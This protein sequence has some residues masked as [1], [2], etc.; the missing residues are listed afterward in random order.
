MH[1][2]DDPQELMT[3]NWGGLLS[4][5]IWHLVEIYGS[6]G[7][8]FSLTYLGS[9]YKACKQLQANKQTGKRANVPLFAA[10]CLL[11]L[12][13]DPE[14]VGST[15]LRHICNLLLNYASQLPRRQYFCD[16]IGTW[17]DHSGLAVYGMKRFHPLGRWD[18]VF[19]SNSRHGYLAVLSLYLSRY[20]LCDGLVLRPRSPTYSLRIKKL[21]WNKALH[22]AK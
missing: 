10:F 13:F 21:K 19:E 5:G 14:H 12:F 18:C 11:D 15:Y 4:R 2:V 17:V 20:R 16:R 9:T 22:A 6:A 1:I 8:T 7:E 3:L